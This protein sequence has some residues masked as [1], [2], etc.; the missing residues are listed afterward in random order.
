MKD[1][2]RMKA[3]LFL[4]KYLKTNEKKIA[5]MKRNRK[6]VMIFVHRHY[7]TVDH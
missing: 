5:E 4:E 7:H 6:I 1:D 2:Y 3:K